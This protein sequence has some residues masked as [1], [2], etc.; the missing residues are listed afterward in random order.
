MEVKV[1][2]NVFLSDLFALLKGKAPVTSEIHIDS[3]KWQQ[4]KSFINFAWIFGNNHKK[5]KKTNLQ[6]PCE[7]CV[8]KNA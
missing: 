8:L 3:K 5:K 2:F 4:N 7:T 6:T 1:S